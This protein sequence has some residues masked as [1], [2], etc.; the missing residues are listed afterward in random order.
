MILPSRT[1]ETQRT[2][3]CR[4]HAAVWLGRRQG[5]PSAQPCYRTGFAPAFCED[6]ADGAIRHFFYVGEPG[7]AERLAESL[8]TRSRAERSRTCSPPFRHLVRTKM[9][10]W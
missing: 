7:V 1:F 6:V 2:W 3:W 8:T 4:R 10:K 9:K 5:T